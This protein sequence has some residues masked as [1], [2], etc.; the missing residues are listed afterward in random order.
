MQNTAHGWASFPPFLH[1]Q[2]RD[3]PK[4]ASLWAMNS[5]ETPQEVPSLQACTPDPS[6]GTRYRG[7][8]PVDA[9]CPSLGEDQKQHVPAKQNPWAV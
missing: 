8:F 3:A 7:G 4:P 2:D 5:Q 6:W 1:I 9:L